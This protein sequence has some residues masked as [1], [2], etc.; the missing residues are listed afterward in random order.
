MYIIWLPIN[1]EFRVISDTSWKWSAAELWEWIAQLNCTHSWRKAGVISVCWLNVC[2]RKIAKG[3]EAVASRFLRSISSILEIANI[4]EYIFV[5]IPW[6]RFQFLRH[7]WV[8]CSNH[9][10]SLAKRFN[11][12]VKTWDQSVSVGVAMFSSNVVQE[13]NLAVMGRT[14]NYWGKRGWGT[15]K[16]VSPAM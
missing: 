13:K 4:W 10:K 16:M 5:D 9:E 1:F 7:F 8:C 12:N 11:I 2:Y 15:S 6:K 14:N 3:S